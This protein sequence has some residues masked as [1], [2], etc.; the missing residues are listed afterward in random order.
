MKGI[1]LKAGVYSSMVTTGASGGVYV[2]GLFGVVAI[3]VAFE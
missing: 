3:V 1:E 2:E